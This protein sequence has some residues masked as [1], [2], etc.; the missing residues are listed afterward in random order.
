VRGMLLL[1]L[2]GS[3][4]RGYLSISCQAGGRA[5]RC[6]VRRGAGWRARDEERIRRR[7]VCR[8]VV[9]RVVRRIVAVQCG[10]R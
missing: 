4:A 7:K 5:A 9:P 6:A 3:G 8:L 10:I 2:L 1:V